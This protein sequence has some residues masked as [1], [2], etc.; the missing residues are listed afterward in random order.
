VKISEIRGEKFS[1]AKAKCTKVH[2]FKLKFETNKK[3]PK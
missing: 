3:G 1:E 2:S